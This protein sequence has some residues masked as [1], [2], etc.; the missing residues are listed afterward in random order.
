MFFSK[1][2]LITLATAGMA[3]AAAF[4][5]SHNAG[6]QRRDMLRQEIE[7]KGVSSFWRDDEQPTDEVERRAMGLTGSSFWASTE[8]PAED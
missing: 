1:P 4:A 7:K 8:E 2:A 3:M 5:N 6:V